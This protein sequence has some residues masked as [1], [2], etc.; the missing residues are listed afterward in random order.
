MNCQGSEQFP[1]F[2]GP[3]GKFGST[4]ELVSW[5]NRTNS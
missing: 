3:D 4:K 2:G 5:K 1:S